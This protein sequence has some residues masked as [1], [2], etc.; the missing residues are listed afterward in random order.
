MRSFLIVL[1]LI[2]ACAKAEPPAAATK[3]AP[4]PE[5]KK[6]TY[7]HVS[8]GPAVSPSEIL[9]KI[10]EYD[11]KVMRVQGTVAAV[12][13]HRGCWMDIAGVDGST[14]R[15][16]VKDGEVVFPKTATGKKVIAEGVV[17]KIPADPADDKTSCEGGEGHA[18][19]Q[20]A[21]HEDCARPKG[22]SARID[23]SGAVIFES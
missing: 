6:A 1:S 22:A 17:V 18:E 13:Q 14:I 4:T 19:A 21:E 12:C 8:E 9:A 11:G 10:D 2:C 20:G 16:K 15:I 5:V 7:G 3:P 23:G